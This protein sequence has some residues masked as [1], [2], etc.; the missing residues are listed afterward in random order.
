[1]ISRKALA[2]VFACSLTFTTA[3]AGKE[4]KQGSKTKIVTGFAIAAGLAA[5]A[6][7]YFGRRGSSLADAESTVAA[8][9]GILTGLGCAVVEHYSQKT[10]PHGTTLLPLIAFCSWNGERVMRQQIFDDAAL[11]G[12]SN[13]NSGRKASWISYLVYYGA[14]Y[15]DSN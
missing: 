7:G 14:R 9:I 12:S 3:H 4:F 8:G 13:W 15:A 5:L 2:L 6:K 10:I 1:M 11:S